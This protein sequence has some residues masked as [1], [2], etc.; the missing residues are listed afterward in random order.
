[1]D[2]RLSNGNIKFTN[3]I[4]RLDRFEKITRHY[5]NNDLGYFSPSY[6]ERQRQIDV[7]SN[8]LAGEHFLDFASIDW[9]VSRSAST[10]RHPSDITFSFQE[11]GALNID[12]IEDPAYTAYDLI[13]VAKRDLNKTGLFDVN[14]RKEESIEVDYAA[15]LN[16]KLPYTITNTIA[17][18]VKFGG[19]YR[20][21]SRDRDTSRDRASSHHISG[22][23]LIERYH[24]QY[25]T[26]SFEFLRALGG[27]PHISNYMDPNFAAENFLNGRYAFD[28]GFNADE[29]MRLQ[30]LY[31]YDNVSIPHLNA[32]LSDYEIDEKIASGYLMAE[33]HLGRIF[34][35]MPGVRYEYTHNN[36]NGRKGFITTVDVDIDP[37][38]PIVEDTSA[39]KWYDNWFPM[40]QMRVRPLDWF[41][42]RLAY[43]ESISRP[44]HAWMLPNKSQ[45]AREVSLGNPNLRPQISTNYDLFL[46]FY[47]NKIGLL[48]LGAFHK[49]IDDLIFKRNNHS[50]LT[51]EE[52]EFYGF[53]PDI[54]LGADLDIAEN[55]PFETKLDGFEFEWQ[56]NFYWLPSPFDGLVLTVNYTH[57]WSETRYPRS[58]VLEEKIDTF[59]FLL[60]TVVDSFRVGKMINQPDD[61][62]NAS[63]GY[64]K[65]P[66]STRV[67]V[68]YQGRTLRGIG[69]IPNEDSF[70][71]DILRTDLSVRYRLTK[72]FS[73]FLNVNN[74]TSEPD[75]SYQLSN[76]WGERFP[77]ALEYYGWT[78]DFGIGFAN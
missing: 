19:R 42:I 21:K 70:T 25:G 30:K 16:L 51:A 4:S 62:F 31:L 8:S 22:D 61:V 78:L 29:L 12:E 32:D 64:D 76:K 44:R 27:K 75:E 38:D 20:D 52:V 17:G 68:L 2:Y 23:T 47:G 5:Y 74:I 26:P 57:I 40:L 35:L 48:T 9:R 39:V 54:A 24:S 66:F 6:R 41:D 71:E 45:Y 11:P 13:N 58:V 55:I 60:K 33:L 43:T 69:D 72:N 10:T 46:S 7:L 63:L 56:A 59:P 1:M 50:L 65:G 3:L 53:N 49:D 28:L 36:L 73:L 77:R 15:Q 67:S 34:M 37:A 18:Y 14:F